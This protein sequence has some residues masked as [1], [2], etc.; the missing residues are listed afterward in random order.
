MLSLP[1]AE[2]SCSIRANA[3]ETLYTEEM[4]ESFKAGDQARL[5]LF[6]FLLRSEANFVFSV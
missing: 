3:V 5:V 4:R 2:G 6:L 1:K